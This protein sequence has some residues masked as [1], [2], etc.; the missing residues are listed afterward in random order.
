VDVRGSRVR[1]PSPTSVPINRS[2]FGTA[3]RFAVFVDFGVLLRGMQEIGKG[4]DKPVRFLY[5]KS[6]RCTEIP[7][8]ADEKSE[9]LR[10]AVNLAPIAKIELLG[11]GGRAFIAG[12]GVFDGFALRMGANGAFSSMSGQGSAAFRSGPSG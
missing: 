4:G 6:K 10:V 9:R 5:E 12:K 1:S 7:I 3:D 11:D 8:P 2:G